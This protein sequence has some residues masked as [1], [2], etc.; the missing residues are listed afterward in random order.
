VVNY[1][2]VLIIKEDMTV[3][4]SLPLIWATKISCLPTTLDHI[5]LLAGGIEKVYPQFSER[6]DGPLSESAE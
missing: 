3:L 5:I 2:S 6:Q 1:V 4:I